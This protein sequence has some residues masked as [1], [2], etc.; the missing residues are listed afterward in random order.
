M[1]HGLSSQEAQRLALEESERQMR[2][3][4][5]A[6]RKH[7]VQSLRHGFMVCTNSPKGSKYLYIG[8]KVR[9]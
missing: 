3:E 5:E 4:E 1:S 8:S 6:D 9:I 7:H 2:D